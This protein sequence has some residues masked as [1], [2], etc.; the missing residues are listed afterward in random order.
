MLAAVLVATTFLTGGAFAHEGS[1][2]PKKPTAAAAELKSARNKLDAAKKKLA[3]Q[4]KYSCCLKKSCDICARR[5]GSC[6]CAANVAAGKGA[7]GECQAGWLAGRGAMKG[8]DPQAVKLL[9]SSHQGMRH[10]AGPTETA[11]SLNEA[12]G[13]LT[14]AKKTL[15]K[16]G[17]FACCIKGGCDECAFETDCP[18][19]SDLAQGKGVCGSCA[20]GWHAGDGM[21]PGLA[22]SEIH[23]APMSDSMHD[24]MAMGMSS[25]TS[26]Q[27]EAAF[28][29]SET[30]NIAPMSM[31]MGR[32]SRAGGWDWMLAANVFVVGTAQSGPRGGDGVFSA[33]W[34]MP[35]FGRKLGRGYLT[36]RP[37]FSFEPATVRNG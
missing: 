25:G 16:E 1:K 5:N 24:G 33:N 30:S 32:T 3:S 31:L 9:D 37:M 4:G 8:V 10:G 18:C 2:K 29:E 23:I 7:C 6:N 17:R 26:Q 19:G 21:F 20:D 27:P 28:V 11:N 14:A 35:M 34:V 22:L 13:E 15:V 12:L 36:L